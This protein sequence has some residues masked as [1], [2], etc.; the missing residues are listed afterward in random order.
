MKEKFFFENITVFYISAAFS[1]LAYV[2]L[3]FV[4]SFLTLKS[5][6]FRLHELQVIPLQSH[7]EQLFTKK[8]NF[9]F[10]NPI[11]RISEAHSISMFFLLTQLGTKITSD[12]DHF[13]SQHNRGLGGS[14]HS[15]LLRMS[16][17]HRLRV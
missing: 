1:V 6:V 14:P 3:F 16:R 15:V 5:E 7:D 2:W 9:V 13:F 12:P 11:S 4:S 10:E 17:C 8:Y